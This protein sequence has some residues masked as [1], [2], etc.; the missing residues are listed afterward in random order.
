MAPAGTLPATLMGPAT[1]C[2]RY[3]I[4]TG[5]SIMQDTGVSPAR[6]SEKALLSEPLKF[7]ALK[8]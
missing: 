6:D 2:P 4:C 3:H 5:N 1:T 8:F 7:S